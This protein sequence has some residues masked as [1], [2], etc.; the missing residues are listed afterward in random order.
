[1]REVT[2]ATGVV[3]TRHDYDPYGQRTRVTG[4]EDA[5]F[6]FTGH[7]QHAESGLALALYRAYDPALGRWLSEDPIGMVDGPNI[8]G[9]VANRPTTALDP[10]GLEACPKPQDPQER[11]RSLIRRG[12][13]QALGELLRMIEN[14]EIPLMESGVP[15]ARRLAMK[16]IDIISKELKGSVHSEFPRE[17]YEK[18]LE[19]ITQLAKKGDKAAQTAKKLLTQK[20]YRK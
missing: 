13:P 20:E 14:G 3:L 10:L 15:D 7:Y 5:R 1:V 12:D 6:G 16:A 18:T 4:T 2:D 19:Q 17:M 8:Q 11:V 9:Y